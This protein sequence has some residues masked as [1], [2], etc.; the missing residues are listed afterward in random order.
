M[1]HGTAVSIKTAA[2]SITKHH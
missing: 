1:K 2:I